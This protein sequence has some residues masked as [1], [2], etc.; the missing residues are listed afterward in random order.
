MNEQRIEINLSFKCF[1][2]SFQL[3]SSEHVDKW[4]EMSKIDACVDNEQIKHA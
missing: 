1:N 3:R 2:E 4:N